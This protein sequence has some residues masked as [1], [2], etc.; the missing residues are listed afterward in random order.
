MGRPKMLLPWGTT[1]IIG[2]IIQQWRSLQA[3]QI[4]VV[5]ASRDEAVQSELDHLKF[6]KEDR[7]IN[8]HPEEG[9]FSSIQCAANWKQWENDLTHWCIVLGD[10]PQLPLKLLEELVHFAF[11]H[12]LRICVPRQGG[13]RRHPVFLPQ[14]LFQKLAGSKADNLKEFLDQYCDDVAFCEINDPAFEL[15]ID[16]PE[17]YQKAARFY[18]PE[19]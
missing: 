6:S 4:V 7:I 9:M 19:S 16:Y 2:H 18:L 12:P 3:Q 17:D 10:Q 8:L 15:D 1:S 11:A 14:K 5:L 13:H